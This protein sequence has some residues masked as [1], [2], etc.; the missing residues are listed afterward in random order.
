MP[1]THWQVLPSQTH[2]GRATLS[3]PQ[4]LHSRGSRRRGCGLRACSRTWATL[5]G[6]DPPP[7]LRRRA[8]GL[9]LHPAVAIGSAGRTVQARHCERWQ[10]LIDRPPPVQH[11]AIRRGEVEAIARSL[12]AGYGW[13]GRYSG[14]PAALEAGEQR[15]DTVS[16]TRADPGSKRAI[17]STG[18]HR[19]L[20]AFSRIVAGLRGRPFV[21]LPGSL[22]LGRADRFLF[23]V[24][25]CSTPPPTMTV[26]WN[27]ECPGS[28]HAHGAEREAMRSAV[29]ICALLCST[30]H[31]SRPLLAWSHYVV[32]LNKRAGGQQWK[33]V[34]TVAKSHKRHM[35][36][37]CC[38]SLECTQNF[39]IG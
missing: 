26:W 27:T 15:M 32:S 20:R 16:H 4:L 23:S 39:G 28:M 8:I 30:Q 6:V 1:L 18:T 3:L 11:L 24:L 37:Q 21:S 29:P 31:G 10:S 38:E 35:P 17:H 25:K 12:R 34:R 36:L 22:P 7:Q 14:S 19:D 13:P 33:G 9:P 2:E 5:L